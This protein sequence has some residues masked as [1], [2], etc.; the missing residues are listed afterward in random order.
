MC[1]LLLLPTTFS[2][3]FFQE[4]DIP[5]AITLVGVELR[6]EL[7]QI[8]VEEDAD[9]EDEDEEVEARDSLAFFS[10][11]TGSTTSHVKGT[12]LVDL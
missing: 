6:D 1:Q 5:S 3:C 2:T 11:T 8:D 7:L 9:V 4:E 10:R 12:D